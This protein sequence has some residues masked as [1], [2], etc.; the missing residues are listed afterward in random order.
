MPIT[1]SR[2]I[3]HG[4]DRLHTAPPPLCRRPRHPP[5]LAIGTLNIWDGRGFGLAQAI[6]AVEHR[7]FDVMLLTETNIKTEVYS[8][9]HLG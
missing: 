4:Y 6:W 7:G 5:G 2:P 3:R 9:N 1:F 8:H